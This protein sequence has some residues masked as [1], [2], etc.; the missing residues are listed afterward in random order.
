[1]NKLIVLAFASLVVAL[2]SCE[3]EIRNIADIKEIPPVDNS[4]N[5]PKPIVITPIDINQQGFEFMDKIQGHWVGQNMVINQE[6]PWFAFDFRANSPSQVLGMFEGGSMGNLFNSFFV[7]DYE[8]TRTIMVRNG[9]ILNSI[10]RTSYF[11]LDSIASTGQG[12]YYRFVDAQGSTNSMWMELMFKGDSLSFNAY[13]SKLGVSFPP[14]RHMTFK[15]KKENLI[16]AQTAAAAVNYPQNTPAWNF[17]NGFV[18]D[19]FYLNAGDTVAKSATFLT[20]G[21]FS[22]ETLAALA[23]DPFTITDHPYLS[24]L[25]VTINRNSQIDNTV[26][27]LN[28]SKD[29]LTDANG[30]FIFQ[31]FGSVLLFPELVATA[32]YQEFTYLHPGTYYVTVIADTNGDGLPSPGDITHAAQQ[33]TINPEQQQYITI[34]NINVQN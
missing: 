11:V 26:L 23:K 2:T 7:T 14:S 19:D 34:D 25:G 3:K 18:K 4:D 33:I 5:G 31:N 27:F 29:P 15:G 21:N 24:R 16:L 8:D 12:D 1:M 32:S 6:Y 17:S 20:Q 13:T 30:Y 28:L 9:G 22:I 10:Y